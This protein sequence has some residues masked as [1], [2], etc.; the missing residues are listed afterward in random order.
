MKHDTL[1]FEIGTEELP[2]GYIQPALAALERLMRDKLTESRVACGDI[3]T[4][5]TP[6][7]LAALVA[8]VAEKQERITTDMV[9]P[10][11]R[12]GIDENGNFT[13]P[14]QKF[15]EKAGVGI[16]QLK[17]M[18]TEKGE[19]LSAKK[20]EKG[21]AVTTILKT[22]LPQI[23]SSLPFPKTMKWGDRT[24]LFPR[25]VHS[26]TTLWGSRSV[27]FTWAGVKSGRY[28]SGHAFMAPGRIKIIHPDTYVD[29]LR[30][31]FVIADIDERNAM[32]SRAVKEAAA[33]AG[34]TV[35]EDDELTMMVTNMVEYPVATAGR[36]D[37]A[38]LELP[39]EVL[40]TA[41][42]SHQRY[43][44]VTDAQGNLM[45]AFIAVNNTRANDMAV[46]TTGHQRVLRARLDD[47]MFFY[48]KDIQTP[49][50]DRVEKLKRVLFQAK[51]GSVYDKAIRIAGLARLIADDYI[52]QKTVAAPADPA[53]KDQA[54]RTAMLCKA[55][56]VTL[57]VDEFPKLQGTMGRIYALAAGEPEVVANA[58]EEH[59]QPAYSG[60]VL[61][62]TA[63]GAV[64]AI[65]DKID[66]ICG[67]FAIG[68]VPS[69]A[70]DPY[71]LRRHGIGIIHILLD[72]GMGLSMNGLVASA[73]QR[74]SDV[75]TVPLNEAGAGVLEFLRGR[76]TQLLIDERIS[77]DV[78]TAV[79]NASADNIPDTWQ[80]ARALNRM[81]SRPDFEPIAVA[82]KR[83]A[84][85]IKKSGPDTV[86]GVDTG[87]FDHESEGALY[88]AAN[89]VGEKMAATLKTGNY[90]GALAEIAALREPVD[91]FFDDVMVM[92]DDEKLRN[93][94]LG[95][96]A[97]IAAVFSGF[98]DFS[99]IVT[100]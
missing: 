56:L 63:C 99:A 3:R 18:Q 94:R 69:G 39:P 21:L 59:Y 89:T 23:I 22:L 70:S 79:L 4:F 34:G 36:L 71:A 32:V 13:V 33:A 41:M 27:P 74:F 44:A 66:T 98:A 43:F 40:I 12:V 9:G 1:L 49:L 84:N 90:E 38:F 91:T 80:R 46:V 58:I 92:C 8:N 61:P 85:I 57:V 55:D 47:A 15:A 83:V 65:A 81:K 93:N 30:D 73:M 10:P 76:M 50:P 82:F 95:L 62:A 64:L 24:E 54:E 48:K 51:L 37:D 31:A 53:L 25:P 35:L 52:Q 68:L 5:G 77:K 17:V 19:Y 96:L 86:T 78:V 42:R 100:E 88:N 75:A 87:L 7:R 97:H 29:Q 67:C 2:A 6:R 20:V 11:A 26:L 16:N 28:T 45:P 60:G 72:R 14:A